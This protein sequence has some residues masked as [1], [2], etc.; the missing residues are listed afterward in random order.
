MLI[1]I[2]KDFYCSASA[3]ARASAGNTICFYNDCK[4]CREDNG[5][6]NYRRKHPTPE[7]FKEEYGVD[8]HDGGAVYCKQ[9]RPAE[10]TESP[11]YV[12]S[13]AWFKKE[14]QTYLNHGDELLCVCACTPF[15]KPDRDWRPQ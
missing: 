13:Y 8:Y 4:P 10:G 1:T 7:Q 3:F 14:R 11:W 2:D 9:I 5:C 6:L 12:F 15:G